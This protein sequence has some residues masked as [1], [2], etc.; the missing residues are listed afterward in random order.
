MAALLRLAAR[1]PAQVSS[2]EAS[3]PV[4]NNIIE[5]CRDSTASRFE[6]PEFLIIDENAAQ[7]LSD[8]GDVIG[9]G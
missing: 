8:G 3:R 4:P 9:F 7:A 2:A 1:K 6:R 5:H